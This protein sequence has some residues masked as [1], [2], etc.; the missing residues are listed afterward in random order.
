[1]TYL[2]GIVVLGSRDQFRGKMNVSNLAACLGKYTCHTGVFTGAGWIVPLAYLISNGWIRSYTCDSV[3]AA[4][5]YFGKSCVPGALSPEYV[6]GGAYDNL[7]HL[8]HG[9]SSRY[10]SRDASE[11]YYGF[12][13][14][15]RF[16][17]LYFLNESCSSALYNR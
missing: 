7:C 13:G 17:C 3:H 11:D 16:R 5:E 2:R 1:M 8:C 6:S 4:A 9:S 12:T 15:N 14:F 10:C